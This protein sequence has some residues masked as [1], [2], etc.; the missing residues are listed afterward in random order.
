[1]YHEWQSRNQTAE[2]CAELHM[3]AAGPTCSGKSLV[4]Q[5]T[6]QLLPSLTLVVSPLLALMK[7]Q[8]DALAELGVG[9]GAI[10]S[11]Q[12]ACWRVTYPTARPNRCAM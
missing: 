7:D 4:Y 3:P 11:L 5:L 2:K 1:M 12:W 9:S 10:N 8:V 6:A